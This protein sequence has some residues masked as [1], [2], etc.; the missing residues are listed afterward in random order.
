M[1]AALSAAAVAALAPVSVTV[2]AGPVTA[3]LTGLGAAGGHTLS[4]ATNLRLT[5][6][7]GGAVA[8][9]GPLRP[10]RFGCD[11]TEPPD[12][13]AARVATLRVADLDGDGEAEVLVDRS[14]GFSPCCSL[15]TAILRR[16]PIS[17]AYAE[18]RRHWGE[19]YR[20][21]DL[22]GD[23]RP[24]LM[25]GDL[26]FY[27]RFAPAR[28]GFQLPVKTLALRG[29]ALVDVTRVH[30]AP[31]RRQVRRLS[32]LLRETGAI[33]DGRRPGNRALARAAL[34]P[35]LAAYAADQRLLGRRAVGDR[36]VARE[37][38]H[39]RVSAGFRRALMRFLSA[40]GY[41]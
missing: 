18:L 4:V 10:C 37:V 34:R 30:R 41:R 22:D 19:S 2:T 21:A 5:I 36:R 6:A 11:P 38:A 12:P 33:A 29:P 31:I 9:N 39:G 25:T 14:D 7:R 27:E 23:R 28:V 3:T 1:I 15:E 8:F 26:H 16:D 17:G 35:Q 32:R 13:T 24:E 40:V 20:I